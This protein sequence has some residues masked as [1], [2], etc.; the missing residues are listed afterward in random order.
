M[1]ITY[2]TARDR[3]RGAAGARTVQRRGIELVALCVT[4]IVALAALLI[5]YQA[6]MVP[7]ADVERDVREHRV[8]QLDRVGRPEDLLPGLAALT[9][10]TERRVAAERLFAFLSTP[11]ADGVT[12]S[13][14]SVNT[15]GRVRVTAAEVARDRRLAFL[16]RRFKPTPA[17]TAASEQTVALLSLIHI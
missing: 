5:A 4:S 7:A 12:L 8:V 17:G 11:S 10:P 1:R 16:K 2:S 6:R 3:A 13:I 9:D 14:E 15:F